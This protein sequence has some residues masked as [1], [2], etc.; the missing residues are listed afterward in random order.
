MVRV[1]PGARGR[2]AGKPAVDGDMQPVAD[3]GHHGIGLY[4]GGRI[5]RISAHSFLRG[6][7]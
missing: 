4:N 1:L 7:G 6:V 5:L 2:V 3:V